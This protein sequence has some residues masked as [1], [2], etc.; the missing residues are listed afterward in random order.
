MKPENL[1]AWKLKREIKRLWMQLG[2][3]FDLLTMPIRRWLYDRKKHEIIKYSSGAQPVR[4]NVAIILIFQ[5]NGVRDSLLETLQYFNENGFTPLVVSNSPLS[6]GDL[7]NLCK[8]AYLVMERPNSGYDFGGYR[9]GVLHLLDSEICPENLVL[10]NDSIWFPIRKNCD[11]LEKVK[12]ESADLFGIV[13]SERPDTPSR[14]HLQSYFYSFKQRVVQDSSFREYWEKLYFSENKFLV[15]RKCEMKLTQYFKSRGF[16]LAWFCDQEDLM[17]ALLSLSKPELE[18]VIRY[19]ISIDHKNSKLLKDFLDTR[20]NGDD[21]RKEIPTLIK[22]RNLGKYTLIAHPLIL[23]TR[24]MIPIL[25]RDKQKVYQRQRK[26]I[27]ACGLDGFVSPIAMEE[28]SKEQSALND[29]KG[30]HQGQT[31]TYPSD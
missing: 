20:M 24:L 21:W 8:N 11:F 12:E 1:P 15:I 2:I 28:I 5:P 16:S 9:D 29:D 30:P 25:K 4:E 26:E 17:N 31:E 13:F 14:T 27:L 22:S 10:M 3:P 7:K 19:Q 23:F 6:S 18:T